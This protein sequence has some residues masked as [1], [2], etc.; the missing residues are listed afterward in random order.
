MATTGATIQF[1]S[2]TYA[3]Y[4]ALT[5]KDVDTVYFCEDTK[6][7][8]V[9]ELEFTR[10]DEIENILKELKEKATHQDIQD[11]IDENFV[12]LTQEQYDALPD[13]KYTDNVNYYVKNVDV[14][15]TMTSTILEGT[16]PAG[17]T[18]LTITSNS[19]KEEDSLIDVYTNTSGVCYTDIVIVD[20]YITLTFVAQSTD[21]GVKVRVM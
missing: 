8:F 21:L 15:E 9:G 19:I 14:V 2:G 7:L 4:S 1:R 16:L 3:Q 6:Q 10:K 5:T 17:E 13:T 18:T 12:E 11:K 20:G